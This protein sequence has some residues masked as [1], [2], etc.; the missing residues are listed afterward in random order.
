MIDGNRKNQLD[1]PSLGNRSVQKV[2]VEVSSRHKWITFSS[3]QSNTDTFANS[4]DPGEMAH[5]EP[6]HQDP[7]CLPFH[8]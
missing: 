5:N 4:V 2:E 6:S 3:L 8:Y 1:I 7:H